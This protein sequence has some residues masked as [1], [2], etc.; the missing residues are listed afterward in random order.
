MTF[1]NFLFIL[2]STGNPK[3]AE[4]ILEKIESAHPKLIEI[5]LR[6][7]ALS[8][9]Q[10]NKDEVFKLY[11]KYLNEWKSNSEQHRHYFDGV[12]KYARYCSLVSSKW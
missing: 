4:E 10:N 1:K 5:P 6:R 12:V 9:R 7:I 11:E 3:K 8:K 2:S